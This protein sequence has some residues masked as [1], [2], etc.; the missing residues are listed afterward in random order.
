M[1]KR[2]FAILS[3]LFFVSSIIASAPKT[4]CQ[5]SFFIVTNYGQEPINLITVI[6]ENNPSH[7][8][9]AA[10]YTKKTN[11]IKPLDSRNF[12]S[13]ASYVGVMYVYGA[14]IY[15]TAL[16]KNTDHTVYFDEKNRKFK[17]SQNYE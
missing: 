13:A 16:T 14:I 3:F 12:T 11:C 15:Q 2:Y 1:L 9:T 6:E 8:E 7:M 4:E 10:H 5:N 17:N